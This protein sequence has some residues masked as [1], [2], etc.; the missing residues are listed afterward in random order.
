MAVF[1]EDY[2]AVE[3][4][5]ADFAVDSTV[6]FVAVSVAVFIGAD[7]LDMARDGMGYGAARQ[8]R[9]QVRIRR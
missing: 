1:A 8:L 2:S 9:L 3:R 4:S 6:D 5:A 7:G